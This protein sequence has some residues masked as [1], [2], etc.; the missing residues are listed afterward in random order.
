MVAEAAVWACPLEPS[1]ESVVA[2]GWV[3]AA[4]VEVAAAATEV[5][6]TALVAMAEVMAVEG[7]A[8]A[9]PLAPSEESVVAAGLVTGAMA[10]LTAVASV[11]GAKG[12]G[13]TAG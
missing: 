2:V 13:E 12:S 6:V 10:T 1:E 3:A 4:M 7:A 5:E 8:L 11:V 9:S